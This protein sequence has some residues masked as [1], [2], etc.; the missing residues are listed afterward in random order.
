MNRSVSHLTQPSAD[1]KPSAGIPPTS[2]SIRRI[3]GVPY[4]LGR[5]QHKPVI[6][7]ALW[8]RWVFEGQPL[9]DKFGLVSREAAGAKGRAAS[10]GLSP[11]R[12][13]REGLKCSPSSALCCRSSLLCSASP[14]VRLFFVPLLVQILFSCA[15]SG[16][17]GMQVLETQALGSHTEPQSHRGGK[18]FPQRS[19]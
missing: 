10:V 14:A 1:V 17:T 16:S 11:R 3:K 13:G 2:S 5:D 12:I 19:L 7:K 18:P 15:N 9:K 4:F 8:R 6:D